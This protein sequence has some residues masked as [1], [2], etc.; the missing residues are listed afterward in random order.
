MGACFKWRAFFLFWSGAKDVTATA[1]GSAVGANA[2]NV[3]FSPLF[4][5]FSRRMLMKVMT[6]HRTSLTL[7]IPGTGVEEYAQKL[8]SS[9]FPPFVGS[10]RAGCPVS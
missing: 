7:R 3:F 6:W 5:S 9:F 4:C 2:P 1:F 10:M 8:L